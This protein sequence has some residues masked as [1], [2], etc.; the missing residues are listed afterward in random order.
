MASPFPFTSGQV[1]TAAQLNSI[2][3]WTTYSPTC[4][5]S[6]AGSFGFI[7]YAQV[8]D[9]L[10]LKFKFDLTGAPTGDFA[11]D[12]PF[13]DTDGFGGSMGT[14]VLFDANG[15]DYYATF[16]SSADEIK[17]TALNA[18]TVDATTPFTWA[19]A[20]SIRGILTVENS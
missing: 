13:A 8:Q 10:V 17:M 18:G 16:F 11:F 14:A 6:T 5:W 12:L 19:N 1:L 9:L 20:D 2:G 4:T 3:E 7:K 15:T